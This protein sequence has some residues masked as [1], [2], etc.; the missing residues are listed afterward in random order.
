MVEGWIWGDGENQFPPL[1][2][3]RFDKL[4]VELLHLAKIK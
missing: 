1:W 2:T 3:I 4:F